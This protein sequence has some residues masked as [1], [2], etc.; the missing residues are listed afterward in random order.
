MP[1]APFLLEHLL[2]GGKGGVNRVPP[3][4][5][6]HGQVLVFLCPCFPNGSEE[7]RTAGCFILNLICFGEGGETN[8]W[9]RI[10]CV[11]PRP[12]ATGTHGVSPVHGVSPLG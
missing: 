9:L 5:L 11:S 10:C 6:T 4:P 1:S 3:R 8:P 2:G 12:T 7:L